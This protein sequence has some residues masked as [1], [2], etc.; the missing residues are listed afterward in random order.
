MC[1]GMLSGKLLQ[2]FCPDTAPC[3]SQ[4]RGAGGTGTCD[5]RALW[6]IIGA[7]TA[8]SPLLILVLQ[9]HLL[10]HSYRCRVQR[11]W[12]GKPHCE[13]FGSAVVAATSRDQLQGFWRCGLMQ[14]KTSS[15]SKDVVGCCEV[16]C[17]HD[18][19]ASQSRPCHAAIAGGAS[20]SCLA[21]QWH[22]RSW[23]WVRTD[24]GTQ[25][26]A[27]G[28]ACTSARAACAQRKR[29]WLR[30]WRACCWR[31]RARSGPCSCCGAAAAA[32]RA[33][34][35][36]HGARGARARPPR[37]RGS[38]AGRVGV[39]GGAPPGNKVGCCVGVGFCG[40]FRSVVRFIQGPKRALDVVLA[41]LVAGCRHD[42]KASLFHFVSEVGQCM[43][44]PRCK[45]HEMH[46]FLEFAFMYNIACCYRQNG[47][48]CN[49]TGASVCDI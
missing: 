4:E 24:G 41:S 40:S 16:L 36:D 37:G 30:C 12:I 38:C 33:G 2:D 1:V 27:V 25:C 7:I 18:M 35:A 28:A 15:A 32:K 34:S 43:Q 13:E 19:T 17:C 47:L 21:R 45:C 22:T 8:T 5:A 26:A 44:L 39:G 3:S 10:A 49:D 6:G 20:Q 11:V 23:I 48:L 29:A 46:G 9:V 42:C 31:R 14:H